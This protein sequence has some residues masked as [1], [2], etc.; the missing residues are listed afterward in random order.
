MLSQLAPVATKRLIVKRH[1]FVTVDEGVTK[2]FR[3]DGGEVRACEDAAP[4]V[5]RMYCKLVYVE[6]QK[7]G[8]R[9][10]Y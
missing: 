4:V 9:G 6:Q 2:Y 1:A 10:V 8:E 5:G 7:I 3:D